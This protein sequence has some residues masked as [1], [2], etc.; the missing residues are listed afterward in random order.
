MRHTRCALVTGVQTCALPIFGY[1]H[2]CG[3]SSNGLIPIMAASRHL[4]GTSTSG[5]WPDSGRSVSDQVDGHFD[6]AAG[7]FGVRAGP[8]RF[9]DQV[10]REAALEARKA[11][12]EPGAKNVEDR[13]RAV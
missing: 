8:V 7:C 1:E 10:L 13:K 6:V 11:D 4:A 5:A 12:V 2:P 9:V 3:A